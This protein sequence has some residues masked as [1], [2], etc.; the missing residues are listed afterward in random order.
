M[1]FEDRIYAHAKRVDELREVAQGEEAAKTALILPFLQAM[2]YDAF[3]PRVVVPEYGAAFG[4][5]KAEKVDYAINRDGEPIMLIEAKSAG[6][7]LG[8]G[9]AKQLQYYFNAT[10]TVK[11]GILTNGVVYKFFTDLDRENMM[12]EKPFMVLD[13]SAIEPALIPELKKLC[14]DCFDLDVAIA[15]AQELKYLRHIKKLIAEEVQDPTPEMVKHFARQVCDKPMTA[16]LIES[17]KETVR[18]AFEH[19][20]NDVLNTRLE[21]AM[22]PN[23]YQKA[24]DA[25]AD[26]EEDKVSVLEDPESEGKSVESRIVTTQEEWEAYYLIKSI[27]RDTVDPSR[28]VI[29]D[30]ISYCSVLLDDKN[31]KA[32]CRFH[33]NSKSVKYFETISVAEK[34]GTKHLITDLNDIFQYTDLVKQTVQDMDKQYNN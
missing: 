24:S 18:D 14:N 30:A 11:I 9:C 5:K 17:F 3:D 15:A 1:D 34:K 25:G 26:S 20:I 32:I 6:D 29:R 21:K 2:G 13:F 16:K 33:F 27:L 28:V 31:Y 4:N 19:H 23:S 12:D 8:S 10:P 22:Y 7:P